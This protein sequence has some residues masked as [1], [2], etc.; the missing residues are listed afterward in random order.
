MHSSS[1]KYGVIKDQLLYARIDP[2][3]TAAVPEMAR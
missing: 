3:W 2:A 1:V